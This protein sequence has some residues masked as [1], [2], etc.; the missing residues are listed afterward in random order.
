MTHGK[1]MMD[2]AINLSGQKAMNC[3]VLRMNK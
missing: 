2:N 1:D 3:C